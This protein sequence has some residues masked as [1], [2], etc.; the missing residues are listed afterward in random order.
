MRLIKD[1]LTKLSKDYDKEEPWLGYYNEKTRKI[2]FTDKTIYEYLKESVGQDKD[3]IALNYFGN[4]MSFNELFEKIENASKA[5]RS[6]GVKKGDIVSIGQQIGKMGASGF[7]FGTHLHFGV[8]KGY[9]H[10]GTSVNP[11]RFYR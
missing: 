3:Y 4:K 1:F 5:L 10:R 11:F 7:A 2:K 9:P 8:W 6:L